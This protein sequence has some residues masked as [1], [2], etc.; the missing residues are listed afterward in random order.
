[1]RA[2]FQVRVVGAIIVAELLLSSTY[3]A[4]AQAT[5]EITVSITAH[6]HTGVPLANLP[7]VLEASTGPAAM[8]KTSGDGTL[9]LSGAVPQDDLAVGLSI[10]GGDLPIYSQNERDTLLGI[11][12]IRFLN[13]CFE[14]NRT[15]VLT[16]EISEYAVQ[17]GGTECVT[18]SLSLVNETGGPV[19]GAACSSVAE[20]DE[21]RMLPASSFS[22]RLSRGQPGI[23]YASTEARGVLVRL[24]ANQTQASIELGPLA[25][26]PRTNEG[27]LN[28]TAT[29]LTEM[30]AAQR[31]LYFPGFMLVSPDGQGLYPTTR[32]FTRN[33]AGEY[34]LEVVGAP[35]PAGTFYVVP[36]GYMA[37]PW[38]RGLLDA[39]AAGA[40]LTNSG[41]PRVTIE[42]G[43]SVTM[44]IDV[45]AAYRALF[46]LRR[47]SVQAQNP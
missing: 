40:D 36:T 1:M 8:G 16:T 20:A 43:Q 25:F 11:N 18:A 4:R 23:V 31:N 45:M 30:L 33:A 14:A 7:I 35:V 10:S 42:P 37:P 15:I 12:I 5:R 38:A 47:Y 27:T 22:L 9:V 21:S 29:R 13:H 2:H 41:V 39:I 32:L 44:N 17:I 34:A 46:Q 26:G 3:T 28:I 6:D 19:V 24:T